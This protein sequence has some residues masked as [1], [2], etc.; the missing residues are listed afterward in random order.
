MFQPLVFSCVLETGRGGEL[1]GKKVLWHLKR[2]DSVAE[3]NCRASKKMVLLDLARIFG[4]K[5]N[6]RRIPIWASC[7][8]DSG[9][10]HRQNEKFDVLLFCVVAVNRTATEPCRPF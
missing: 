9:D 2:R 4:L 8:A 10:H 6:Y 7:Q 1:P 5:K 3:P